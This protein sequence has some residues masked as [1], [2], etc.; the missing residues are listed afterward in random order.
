MGALVTT[1]QMAPPS[2]TYALPE[3]GFTAAATNMLA[4]VCRRDGA[5]VVLLAWPAGATYLP[6]DHYVPDE[7][8]V[9]LGHIAGCPIFADTRRL[10]LFPSHDIM[11]DASAGSARLRRP[12]LIATVVHSPGSARGTGGGVTTAGPAP[13]QLCHNLLEELSAEFTPVF[14]PPQIASQVR[15]AIEDLRGSVSTEALPEMAARLAH[16]RLS[17]ATRLRQLGHHR[18]RVSHT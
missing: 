3:V 13:T 16:Q 17:A 10:A 6:R 12:P 9:V 11:L 14:S 1:Q 15:H 18:V 5:Q 4:E 8:D 7:F 2:V